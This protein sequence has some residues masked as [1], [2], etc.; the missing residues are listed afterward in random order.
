MRGTGTAGS[1]VA[2]GACAAGAAILSAQAGFVPL[3]EESHAACSGASA[4]SRPCCSPQ[5]AGQEG[6][7]PF[8]LK[9]HLKSCLCRDVWSVVVL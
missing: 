7:M 3:P 6:T 1:R 2:S 4:G 9:L 5:Q 8:I